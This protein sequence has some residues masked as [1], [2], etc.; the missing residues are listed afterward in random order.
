MRTTETDMQ[1]EKSAQRN[2]K[3]GWV[4]PISLVAIR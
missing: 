1:D 2:R 4:V 3:W